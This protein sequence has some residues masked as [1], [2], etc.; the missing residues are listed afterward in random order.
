MYVWEGEELVSFAVLSPQLHSYEAIVPSESVDV[1]STFAVYPVKLA[2]LKL[3]IGTAFEAVTTYF[4][5]VPF[6]PLLSVI[7]RVTV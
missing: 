1:D 5:R 6:A 3:A 7:S 4:E 2:T